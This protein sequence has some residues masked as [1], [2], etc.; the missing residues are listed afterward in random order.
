MIRLLHIT[1]SY[2]LFAA[3][4]AAMLALPFVHRAGAEPVNPE[5]SRYL[6]M[7]GNLVDI[8]GESGSHKA[9]G[10]ESCAIA[11]TLLIPTCGG[12]ARPAFALASLTLGSTGPVTAPRATPKSSP[13]VRA[14]PR[15]RC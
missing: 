7:G 1:L 10:C 8:C 2:C 15:A 9:G 4:T 3:L 11:A 5:I 6:A 12:P 14:P 13:P